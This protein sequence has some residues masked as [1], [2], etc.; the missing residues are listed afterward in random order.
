MGVYS[1]SWD[2]HDDGGDSDAAAVYVL[3]LI[4]D[5]RVLTQKMVV[6]KWCVTTEAPPAS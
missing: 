5:D 6:A 3:K 1:R 4:A 2:C